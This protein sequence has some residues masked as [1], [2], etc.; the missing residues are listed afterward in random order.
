MSIDEDETVVKD[1]R[2]NWAHAFMVVLV[3]LIIST[4]LAGEYV[5]GAFQ[6]CGGGTHQLSRNVYPDGTV[7]VACKP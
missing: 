7:Y 1:N 2:T 3:V 4:A 6:P 5:I